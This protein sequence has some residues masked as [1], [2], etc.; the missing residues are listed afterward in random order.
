MHR[1]FAPK[2]H[3]FAYRIFLFAID[4]DELA[5]LPRRLR[6]FSVDRPNLYSFRDRDYLPTGEPLHNG[7]ARAA[8]PAPAPAP[9]LKDRV[10][11]YLAE[12]GVDLAGGR[13]LLVTLPRIFGYGFNPVSFYFCTNR[14]GEMVAALTEVTNTFREMKPYYLGP[15]TRT[16]EGGEPTLAFRRRTPKDF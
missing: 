6:L 2:A 8:A 9:A 7:P 14:A 12:R 10:V 13:V 15:E 1:R 4:L 11:A 5:A 3:H 16:P